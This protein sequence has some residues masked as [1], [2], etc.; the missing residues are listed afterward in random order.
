MTRRVAPPPARPRPH[1]ERRGREICDLYS[2]EPWP[3]PDLERIYE[4]TGGVPLLV[5]EQASEWA[6][7]RA[8]RRM[9][10]AG[11]RLAATHRRLVVSR[12]E[13]AD[14]VEGIQRL[15]EQRRAHLAGREAQLDASRIAALGGCP[16]KGLARFEQADASNFFGR[17]RLVAELIARLA[18]SSFLAIV[19]PSG[20]GNRRWSGRDSSLC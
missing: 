1:V 19:G 15:L 2:T 3:A 4:L 10:D 16:Y 20:S 8:S 13:I 11:G 14:G 7:E 9:A 17:E 12:G 18:E 5:H 6:R